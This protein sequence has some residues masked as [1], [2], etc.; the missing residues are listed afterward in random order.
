MTYEEVSRHIQ[1]RYEAHSGRPLPES[2][3]D[4]LVALVHKLP[5]RSGAERRAAILPTGPVEV[6]LPCPHCTWLTYFGREKSKLKVKC[7]STSSPTLP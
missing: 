1:E 2:E 4:E 6:I 3:L 5:C 7:N